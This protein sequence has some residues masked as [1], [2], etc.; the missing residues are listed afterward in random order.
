M[1]DKDFLFRIAFAEMAYALKLRQDCEKTLEKAAD[2]SESAVKHLKEALKKDEVW[3]HH[4][5]S[6]YRRHN[7]LQAPVFH[8]LEA[9]AALRTAGYTQSP[10][11][12]DIWYSEK[13]YSKVKE[14]AP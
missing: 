12:P 1:S 4:L 14:I 11:L 9:E 3:N 7:P 10:R 5:L 8:T 6:L 2:L 13:Y